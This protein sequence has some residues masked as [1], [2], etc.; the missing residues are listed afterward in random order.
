MITKLAISANEI[1]FS[2]CHN[3]FQASPQSNDSLFEFALLLQL[4][5]V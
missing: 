5:V 2:A 1:C 3:N 4:S